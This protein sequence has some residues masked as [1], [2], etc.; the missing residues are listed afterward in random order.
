[1]QLTQQRTI[2]KT[3]IMQGIGLHSGEQ[4]TL[5]F[6]PSAPNTGVV[7]KRTDLSGM[8]TIAA[9]ALLIQ[10][11][12]MSSNLVQDG[13]KVGTVEHLLSAIAGLS[14]DNLVIEVSAAEIPIMD[15][16]ATQFVDVL[17]TA[18]ICDQ[19]TPK[20]YLSL[21][22]TVRVEDGDKWAQLSPAAHFELNFEI[23]FNHPAINNTGQVASIIL[24]PESYANELC[25]ARTFGF[26]KD[27]EQLKANNLA[28]GG[29]LD[30][31]IVLDEDTIMNE[32]GLRMSDEFVKHKILD[33]VGDL[34]LI[35]YPILGKFEAYKS[36]HGLNNALVRKVLGDKSNYEILG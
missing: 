16:S 31:A 30:N 8:P 36:G 12:M 26:L 13:I 35:G 18:D 32:Q 17:K 10:D 22:K 21:L 15:G 34:F 9:N 6:K 5:K 25:N 2:K 29:S 7:F 3:V 20:R 33:A 23:D 19:E 14:I 24:T 11:T 4:V 28:L 27:I 1:M